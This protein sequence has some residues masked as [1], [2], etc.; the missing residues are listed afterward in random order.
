MT[1]LKIEI[2]QETCNYLQ[3]LAYE[4]STR[5]GVVSRMLEDAKN[6]VDTS[7]FDS[8]PFK[9]YHKLLEEAVYSYDVAK[10]ELQDQ[11]KEE[12]AKRFGEDTTFSWSLDDFTVPEVSVTVEA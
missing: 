10:N 7:L 9:H 8:V 12:V 4:V 11:L 6:E 5:Q 2:S 3:R 1:N